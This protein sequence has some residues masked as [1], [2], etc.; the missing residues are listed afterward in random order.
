MSRVG[1][2]VAAWCICDCGAVDM[3]ENLKHCEGEAKAELIAL[4]AWW[5]RIR[6]Y[7]WGCVRGE[8][9]SAGTNGAGVPRVLVLIC[10]GGRTVM[11][12]NR[13]EAKEG[14]SGTMLGVGCHQQGALVD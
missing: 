9:V 8:M 14:E 10:D 6:E 1:A 11:A 2:L 12:E 3:A 13:A 4:C 7:V 5:G